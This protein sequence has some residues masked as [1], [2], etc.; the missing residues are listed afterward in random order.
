MKKSLIY[1]VAL[2]A[3]LLLSAPVA[4][5]QSVLDVPPLDAELTTLA[6]QIVTQQLDD[7]DAANKTFTKM[8]RKIRNNKDE[9]VSAGQYFLDKKVYPCAKICADQAYKLDPQYLPALMLGGNVYMAFKDYG[10]AGQ[11]FDEA[12]LVD[13]T[14]TQALKL[15][16]FVY[17]N[18]NPAVAIEALTSI[19]RLEP[20]NYEVDKDLGDIDYNMS[21]YKTAVKFYDGYFKGV[22]ADSLSERSMENYLNSL[23]ATSNFVKALNV[24]KVVEPRFPN[25]MIFKRM[26]F[27][28]NY[29]NYDLPAT[30]A[31]M[32]YLTSGQFADSLYIYLDYA[33]AAKYMKEKGDTLN[34]INY[35][36]KAV[37]RDTAR[38]AGYKELS[39]MYQA[40][41]QYDKAIEA[42]QV[43]LQKLGD[44]AQP[45]DHIQL[46]LLNYYASQ[47]AADDQKTAYVT[48]G[49]NIFTQIS[50]DVPDSY[51]GPLWNARINNVDDK[52]PLDNVKAYYEEAYKRIGDNEKAKSAKLE[53]LQ[54]FAWYCLQKDLNDDAIKYSDLILEI[55]PDNQ[56]AT[57]IKKF[58]GG[59]NK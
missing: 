15:K 10:T 32:S 44:K 23:Y 11:R 38:A 40:G 37:E 14:L 13:S 53:C 31:A 28:C 8:L 41:K 36:A 55:A 58:L 24:L 5:A 43:Y 6:D 12:L 42:Y 9:L 59:Q 39:S 19:K 17:K 26:S 51:L 33:Y 46:G 1:R 57:Q 52:T 45:T 16:A 35:M 49:S 2:G 29:E 27:I 20:T 7:P 34:A 56:M 22:P 3:L 47:A 4:K 21:K 54:Y 48:A 25:N 50:E 18:V 30:E